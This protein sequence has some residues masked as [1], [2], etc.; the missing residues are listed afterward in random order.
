MPIIRCTLLTKAF[1]KRIRRLYY[2]MAITSVS[3]L[4]AMAVGGIEALG[5]GAAQF[6]LKGAFWDSVHRLNDK[7]GILDHCII[8]LFAMSWVVSIVIYRWGRLDRFE[9]KTR[10]LVSFGNQ[11]S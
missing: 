1:V 3:V 4:V 2:N 5:L 11:F 8:A 9:V 6:Q 7:C 10:E